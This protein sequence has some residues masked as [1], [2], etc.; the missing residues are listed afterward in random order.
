MLPQ[1]SSLAAPGLDPTLAQGYSSN[2]QKARIITESWVS[3]H[4]YCPACG[5]EALTRYEANRPVADF[6]CGSCRSDFELKSKRQAK[7]TPGKRITDGA[8]ASMMERLHSTTNP[9]LIFMIHDGL[10]VMNLCFIPGHFFTASCIEARKPL[11]ANA[12]RAGWQGCNIRLDLIPEAGKI[13]LIRHAQWVA[14]EAALEQYRLSER[15]RTDDLRHRGWMMDILRCLDDIPSAQFELS[16]LYAFEDKLSTLHPDNHN[17]RAKIR[18]QLQ[19]LRNRGIIEFT[20][21]GQYRKM[22]KSI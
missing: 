6:C 18:Q 1:R 17:I 12:R 20:S 11:G 9:H 7:P 14:R 15:M 13:Y 21:R 4:L 8:Y 5:H 16:E 3:R 19:F 2:S 22:F 10:R